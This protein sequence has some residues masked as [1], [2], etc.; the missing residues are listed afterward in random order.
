MFTTTCPHNGCGKVFTKDTASRVKTTLWAHMKNVHHKKISRFEMT[1]KEVGSGVIPAA[2]DAAL[3]EE[4][5]RKKYT[6]KSA[7]ITVNF[8]PVCGCDNRAVALAMSVASRM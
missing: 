1:V 5:P 3:A 7:Q 8:C 6:K 4:K 2:Q